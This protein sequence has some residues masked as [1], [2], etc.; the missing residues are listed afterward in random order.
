MP[1]ILLAV[2]IAAFLWALL[3]R[4]WSRWRQT[5]VIVKPA[6][7][8][9]WH[10]KGFRLFWRWKSRP[11]RPGRP[12]ISAEIRRLIEEMA[13]ANVGWGAPRIHGELKKL[14][15]RMSEATVSRYMPKR[16]T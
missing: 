13:L 11:R 15:I 6:T 16:P 4:W 3:A 9:A 8:I 5:L 10:R 1:H 14:G 2:L 12:P 7:V